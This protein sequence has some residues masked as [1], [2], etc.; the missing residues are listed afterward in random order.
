MEIID[1]KRPWGEERIFIKNQPATVKILLVR[2]GQRFSLQYHNN[3]EEFW[4][5][6]SGSPEIIIDQ[7]KITAK[8]GEEFFIHKG[9]KH[10]I[11][12]G[13]DDAVIMEIGIGDF[14]END[15]VRLE[16]DYNRI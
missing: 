3:R 6:I 11:T 9:S 14:D 7:E 1:D 16:D 2:A 5:V 12:A 4:K 8:N 10:R 15:I 13:K